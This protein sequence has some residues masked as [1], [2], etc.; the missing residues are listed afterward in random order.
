MLISLVTLVALFLSAPG[1][2]DAVLG[3]VVWYAAGLVWFALVGRKRL[4][5][6]PEERFALVAEGDPD[7]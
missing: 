7:A 4:L 2:R 5:R 3:A 6:S 1:Y